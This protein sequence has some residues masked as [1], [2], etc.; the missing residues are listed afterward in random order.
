M[1]VQ[2][3]L[4]IVSPRNYLEPRTARSR[5]REDIFPCLTGA[6]ALDPLLQYVYRLAASRNQG[7]STGDYSRALEYLSDQ[8]AFGLIVHTYVMIHVPVT[9][10]PVSMKKQ[11]VNDLFTAKGE[12]FTIR[13]GATKY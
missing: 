7:L 9:V 5:A 6:A 1:T 2:S 4:G 13:L 10:G 12:C 11:T 8:D 3:K